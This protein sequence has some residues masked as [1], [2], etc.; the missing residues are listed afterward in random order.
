MIRLITLKEGAVLSMLVFTND[1]CV[2]C[3][4]CVHACPCPGANIAEILEDG[5]NKIHVSQDHC[6]GCGA[7]IEACPHGARDYEDDTER[8]FNDLKAGKKISILIAPAFKAN[9]PSEYE[10]ILGQLKSCGVNRIISISFG[11]D[12]TTWAYIKYIT[13]H[14]FYGGIS[15]PCPAVVGYVEKYEPDLIPMLMPVHSPMMCG[16]IYAKKYMN[17]TDDLAFISPCVAKKLEIDD[18]N[19][20]GYVKY[21]VTM[22]KL[23]EYL[24]ANPVSGASNATDEIEYGLGSFYPMPGGLKE[25]VYWLLGEDTYIRQVEGQEHMYSYLKGNKS[26]IK[27]RKNPYLFIDA[28]NCG[29]GCIYG[30]GIESQNYGN[31]AIYGNALKI[32]A[33]SKNDKKKDPWSRALTPAKRLEALNKQFKDLKLEDFIR[34]YTNKHEMVKLTKHT[35]AEEDAMFNEMFKFTPESREINCS[36]CGYDTCVIMARAT[37]DGNN[38][39]ENCIYYSR[40]VARRKNDEVNRLLEEL[41]ESNRATKER[42]EQLSGRINESFE[43]ID[44]SIEAIEVASKQNAK[45]SIDISDSMLEV[46]SIATELK[47][48]FE[49]IQKYL[50]SLSDNNDSVISIASQTNLLALNASIEAARA[51]EA[52]RGFAVVAEEIKVLAENSKQTADDSNVN[53]KDIKTS[54]EHLM[55]VTDKLT[56]II[57]NV[58]DRSQSL[59]ATSQQTTSSVNEVL[60]NVDEVKD[61]LASML[62]DA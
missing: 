58:N 17:V 47:D 27:D 31:E 35:V 59:A 6:I 15:Q 19:C 23:R 29:G 43:E 45:E 37:M 57:N 4:K 34:K 40:E 3:N 20:G 5:S 22:K 13:E 32:K 1:K 48:T 18:P 62:E 46:K 2:G 12:I 61:K 8:F 38:H 28:L 51:G 25:N 21:N 14:K 16:A 53:N 42:N 33:D 24:K 49:Q 52:G 55:Q 60:S 30:T 44:A 26:V 56:D 9:Y 54:V 7:C 11:A 50:E 41:N 10:K 39:K 36:C